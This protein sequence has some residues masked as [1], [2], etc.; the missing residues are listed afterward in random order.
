MVTQFQCKLA[1]LYEA[2]ITLLSRTIALF[3]IAVNSL[4]FGRGAGFLTPSRLQIVETLEI[5]GKR[6][7]TRMRRWYSHVNWWCL[8]TILAERNIS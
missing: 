2:G 3:K 6:L 5:H 7:E 1:Q 4:E 8:H